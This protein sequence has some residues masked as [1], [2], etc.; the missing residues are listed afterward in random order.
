[1]K[2]TALIYGALGLIP[3]TAIGIFLPLW[4]Q[5]WKHEI[6][7]IFNSYSAMILAFLSGSIWGIANSCK[8]LSKLN[9]CLSIGILFS[10]VS[11]AVLL[12]PM[13]YSI[14][15]LVI[16]FAVLLVM[17]AKLMFPQIYPLWYI[18]MRA[19]LTIVVIFC[20]VFFIYWLNDTRLFD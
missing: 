3:F 19:L 6:V 10:L 17:E 16:S 7:N 8:K 13:P 14:Y 12:I 20:H 9:M 18:K 11:F 1:M 2:L 4:P 15:L 5:I